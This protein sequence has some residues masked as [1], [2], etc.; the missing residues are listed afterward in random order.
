MDLQAEGAGAAR[1][2]L[3]DPPHADDAEPLAPD[4]VAE[5]PGRRPAVPLAMLEHL[6]ALG[7]PPRHRKDECHG[8]VG[9]VLCED[10]RR[11]GHDD[12]VRVRRLDVD[13][14]DAGAEIGDQLELI[15][16]LADHGVVDA[17][18][19]G[20]NQH[21][22][23]LHRVCEVGLAH[24]FVV[25]VEL[26]VE[27]LA[28]AGL[29]PVGQLASD[30]DDRLLGFG[31]VLRWGVGTWQKVTTRSPPARFLRSVQ[32][33]LTLPPDTALPFVGGST[34]TLYQKT[35][36]E[37]GARALAGRRWALVR[38]VVRALVYG[39]EWRSC[40]RRARHWFPQRPSGSALREP[41][42]RSGECP[43]RS[44]P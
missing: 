2:R 35:R 13:V 19:D 33:S 25:E 30:D 3:A 41:E 34:G 5:H 17:I 38:A 6:E 20:G 7:E 22:R 10:T 4:A 32:A 8:H 44:D 29:D 21:V 31:H 28:H 1:H 12:A 15:A 16:G 37:Q 18:R 14:V 24:R 11:V 36:S 40:G 9:S 43:R 23:D 26:R 27:Q 42:A 39:R